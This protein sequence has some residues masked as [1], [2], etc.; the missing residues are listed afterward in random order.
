[1]GESMLAS[2]IEEFHMVCA[3]TT[4]SGREAELPPWVW[5]VQSR[6][7]PNRAV[8]EGGGVTNVE[9]PDERDLRQ[10]IQATI[11][12]DVTWLACALDVM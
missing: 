7:L 8:G 1:M 11:G 4:S 9:K 5:A 6:L 10:V 2:H 12:S 3:G